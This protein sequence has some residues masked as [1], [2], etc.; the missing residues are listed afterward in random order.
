MSAVLNPERRVRDVFVIGASSG[1]IRAVIEVLAELPSDLPASIGVVIHRGAASFSD[2]S[3]TLGSKSQLRVVEPKSGDLLVQGVVYVAPADCHMTFEDGHILLDGGVKEHHTRPAVDPL[4]ISAAEAYGARVVGIILTGGGH[5]GMEGL[6]A[7]SA[8]EGI[9]I[10]QKPSE[11]EHASMP[12]YALANDHVLALLSLEEIG[13]AI[14][15][16]ARGEEV[17][18]D[19]DDRVA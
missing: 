17:P 13:D 19:A 6:R 3:R 10:V 2:W 14:A 1:G 9:S 12:A 7:V 16:M 4:F 15:R 11:A 18:I 8:A 5:D